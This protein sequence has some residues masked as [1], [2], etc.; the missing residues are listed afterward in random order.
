MFHLHQAKHEQHVTK[1]VGASA[2]QFLN[3]IVIGHMAVLIA[4][5]LFSVPSIFH[6]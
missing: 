2:C 6:N 1:R 5:L 3:T 4:S